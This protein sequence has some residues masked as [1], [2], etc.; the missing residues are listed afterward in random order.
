MID[1]GNGPPLVLIP[2]MQGRWEWMQPTVN[3]LAAT[4]SAVVRKAT[5]QQ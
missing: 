4:L 3:A 5:E 1:V 2:G